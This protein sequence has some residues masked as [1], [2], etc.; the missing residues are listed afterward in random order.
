MNYCENCKVKVK[1]AAA[2][3]PLCGERLTEKAPAG[4]N[5]APCENSYPV[6]I[7]HFYRYNFWLRL[8]A[9]ASAAGV[10]SCVL[11][12]LLTSGDFR[13]G[14]SVIVVVG[15]CYVWLTCAYSL[16]SAGN[17][18]LHY[19]LQIACISIIL[20]IIDAYAGF[21]RWSLN[22]AVPALLFAATLVI[23]VL[24]CVKY[25]RY[26]DYLFC[27]LVI[28]VFGLVPLVFVPLKAVTV[29]WPSLTTGIFSLIA[30]GGTC[31]FADRSV[32]NE[33]KK[34]FHL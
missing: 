15:V 9:F 24:I 5:D 19:S 2:R 32:K 20:F 18:T 25:M 12:D 23:S 10:L 16:R 8:A 29:R 30:L 26:N 22:Y 27:Q 3:C 17:F 6:I 14:W 31:I 34:R 33:L 7:E 21:H 4:Q 13:L 11:A 28:G 1:N